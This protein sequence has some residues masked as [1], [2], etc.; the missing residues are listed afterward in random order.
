MGLAGYAK[1]TLRALLPLLPLLPR[2]DDRSFLEWRR[3]A[4]GIGGR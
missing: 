3:P 2:N 1:A 4:C